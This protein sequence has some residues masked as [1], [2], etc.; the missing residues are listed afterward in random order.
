[1]CE[2]VCACTS[3]GGAY[4]PSL[5]SAVLALAD[6]RA[7][8]LADGSDARADPHAYALA[9]DR[10]HDQCAGRCAVG[11]VSTL[12]PRLSTF[13][14]PLSALECTVYYLQYPLD[15]ALRAPIECPGMHPLGPPY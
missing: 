2:W 5:R 14:H 9:H 3:F 12:K 15:T 6:A 7:D 4:F 1:M 10:A 11:C 13:E 8:A